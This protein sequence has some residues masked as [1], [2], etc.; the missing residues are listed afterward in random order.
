M[1]G[2]VAAGVVVVVGIV[3]AVWLRLRR[4]EVERLLFNSRFGARLLDAFRSNPRVKYP[5][6]KAVNVYVVVVV[7]VVQA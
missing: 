4:L 1:V 2:G 7:V 3:I 5:L 6:L